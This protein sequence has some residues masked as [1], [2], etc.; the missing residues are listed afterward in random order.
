MR[1]AR[2]PSRSAIQRTASATRLPVT[3]IAAGSTPSAASAARPASSGRAA[4]VA[5]GVGA[6][7]IEV[8]GSLV[9]QAVRGIA[10]RDGLLARRTLAGPRRVLVALRRGAGRDDAD[11]ATAG[12][13]PASPSAPTSRS[14][15]S[16]PR[17]PLLRDAVAAHENVPAA[18]LPR[19]ASFVAALAASGLL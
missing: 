14:R 5:D 1:R 10:E 9:A 3:S 15:S 6:A 17:S 16:A 4:L 7:A 12:W 13:W 11:R 19:Y 2:R 8:T 18:G